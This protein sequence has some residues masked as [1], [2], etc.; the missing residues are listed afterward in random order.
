MEEK[1]YFL[2]DRVRFGSIEE[3][4]EPTRILDFFICGAKTVL[5]V[6]D[7][8]TVWGFYERDK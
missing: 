3:A 4:G 8:T 5:L 7:A 2:K 6:A 1:G